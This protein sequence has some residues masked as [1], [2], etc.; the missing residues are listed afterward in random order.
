MSKAER[1]EGAE[2]MKREEAKGEMC[3]G[4]G[5]SQRHVLV[6]L[7]VLKVAARN[8]TNVVAC[9]GGVEGRKV[10]RCDF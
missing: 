3:R 6:F 4:E 7:L 10:R 2:A 9:R 1:S 5:K 8:A